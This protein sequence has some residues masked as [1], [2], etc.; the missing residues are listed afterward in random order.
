MN[1]ET[2]TVLEDE[3]GLR[4]DRYL[5]RHQPGLTQGIIQK[6]C[7]TGQIRLD[8]KRT[9]PSA[10]VV[11]GQAVRIPPLQPPKPKERQIVSVDEHQRK[12]L[13][14]RILYRD[15]DVIVFDKPSGLAT[16][17]GKGISV[18][19]D[20]MLD[21]L[22]F[23]QTQR[24]R[25]VH[26]LDRETS[27]VIL[28]ARHAKAAAKLAALFR[29]R[30]IEKTYWA[31]VLGRPMPLE[32]R[33]DQP[34]LK[35]ADHGATRTIPAARDDEDADRALTDYQTLDY[36]GSKFS[37]LALSPLTGRTHQLRAHTAAM[38]TPIL[39]DA[40]YGGGSVMLEDFAPILHLHARRLVL[41][42]PSGGRLIAEAPLPKHMQESFVRLGFDAPK[43]AKTVR[44]TG[45]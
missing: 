12:D 34:L 40:M 26:R 28:I 25:L 9:E 31:I 5:R 29:G 44:V 13:E 8:G 11:A 39:G 17:G 14:R 35:L 43:P 21:A 16:Q 38:G 36:A 42:H 2:Q 22:R 3:T 33:I 37:W 18:H 27:G 1:L 30:D 24:P 4:L 10:R 41:P 20:G 15:D 6:L 23:E 7:R 32:G 19:L 45:S